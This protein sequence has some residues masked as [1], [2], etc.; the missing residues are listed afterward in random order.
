MILEYGVQNFFGFKEGASVSFK[1]P[2]K[3][4][5]VSGYAQMI[6]VKGKNSSGKTNLLK[7]LAFLSDFCFRSFDTYKPKS[8]IHIEPF[9]QNDEPT[10]FYIDFIQ[11]GTTYRYELELTD[12]EVLR[13]TLYRKNSRKVKVIERIKDKFTFTISE[14]DS[15]KVMK[16][17]SNVSFISSYDQYEMDNMALLDDVFTFFR[18][19]L[20]NV[21]YSGMHDSMP[22]IDTI[23]EMLYEDK[24]MLQFTKDI[25]VSCDTGIKNIKIKREKIKETGNYQY[26]PFFYHEAEGNL[27]KLHYF[28]ESSGTKALYCQL[29]RYKVILEGGGFLCLDEFDINLHPHILPMLLDLFDNKETNPKG[30]QILF[31][32]HNSEI[33]EYMGKYRTYLTEKENNECFAYRLD[34]IPSDIIRNDRSILNL[35]NNGKL[36]GVPDL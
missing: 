20:F 26:T 33:M 7:A 17:R 14:F 13:E 5:N 22:N 1:V 34:E 2:N 6:C 18:D 24:F 11:N 25:I 4:P 36:G 9:F 21:G 23:S 31:T 19:I 30:A 29:A 35:Y 3:V 27:H 12:K 32:T 10:E 16:L 15:L 8:Y 28:E